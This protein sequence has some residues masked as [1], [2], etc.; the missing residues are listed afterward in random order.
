MTASAI[1]VPVSCSIPD[2]RPKQ[3]L[4][5]VNGFEITGHDVEYHSLVQ[6]CY[7][8]KE[9]LYEAALSGLVNNAIETEVLRLA[10][11]E[12]ASKDELE[13]RAKLIDE[14]TRAPDVLAK[15][16]A[17]FG[18]DHDAYLGIYVRPF[19][20]NNEL[21]V[22]FSTDR[23]IHAEER[24]K[25]GDIHAQISAGTEMKSFPSYRTFAVTKFLEVPDEIKKKG[26]PPVVNPLV[27]AVLGKLKA[28]ELF[29]DIVEDDYTF[30]IIR[31]LTAD[32]DTYNYEA[33]FVVKKPFDDWFKSFAAKH[34]RVRITDAD[35]EK[36]I[37][38][39][40]G[41]WWLQSLR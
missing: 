37:R 27:D 41:L 5:F 24:K 19:T 16:K 39:I 28:G 17:V 4:C 20:V 36:R 1:L 34:V 32:G 38:S 30:Q 8:Q 25:I 22:R 7:G 21:T 23:E 33:V 14:T 9:I 6:K 31:L 11:G 40:E 12:E 35:T 3:P 18:G 15:I 13:K 29:P 2:T 26:V 10:F